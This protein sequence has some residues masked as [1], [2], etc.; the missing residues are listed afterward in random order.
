L[1]SGQPAAFEVY[2]GAA[3]AFVPVGV[4][5]AA[6]KELAGMYDAQDFAK[7]DGVGHGGKVVRGG[8]GKWDRNQQAPWPPEGEIKMLSGS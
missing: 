4:Y 2:N 3:G 1:L 8:R 6:L 7:V 5:Q